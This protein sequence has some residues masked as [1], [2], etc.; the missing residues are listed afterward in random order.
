MKA[1]RAYKKGEAFRDARLFVIACE[2]EVTEPEYFQYF[3]KVSQRVK[4]TI[5]KPKEGENWNSAPKWVLDRAAS[6]AQ[7][8]GLSSDDQLWL[9]MDVDRWE[10]KTLHEIGDECSKQE[11]W[12]LAITN[13]CFEVWLVMHLAD[14]SDFVE[15]GCQAWKSKLK[16]LV[17]V[18]YSPN[19]LLPY[20]QE[21]IQRAEAVD[22]NPGHYLP[23]PGTTKVYSLAKEILPFIELPQ[24]SL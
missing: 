4:V 7:D 14:T 9:V 3:Q 24:R 2:G 22:K 15:T 16:G 5:I 21:A 11:G 12:N 8:I 13:P 1:N 17:Q 6:Y 19:K 23:E 20:L 10:I 18:G